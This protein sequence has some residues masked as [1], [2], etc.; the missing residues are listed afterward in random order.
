MKP[1]FWFVPLVLVGLGKQFSSASPRPFTSVEL[2]GWIPA[3]GSP[4]T[5][6]LAC[7]T[8]QQRGLLES[9]PHAVRP[10]ARKPNNPQTW[11]LTATG[12]EACR[13]AIQ[14]QARQVRV[15]ALI[16]RNKQPRPSTLYSRLWN[17]LRI[18]AAL[19]AEEA[20]S[21][22]VDAGGNAES[23]QSTASRYMRYWSRVRPDA[24]QISARRVNGFFRY[25]L[26]KDIGATPPDISAIGRKTSEVP[27]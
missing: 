4:T 3:L 2:Q 26:V 14:A 5:A 21:V 24:V 1:A 27:Q 13:T 22:L 19:T 15:D 6:R 11:Q 23:L 25:V 18:R 9:A 17:L 16:E 20:I 8:L 10:G 7:K 12:R